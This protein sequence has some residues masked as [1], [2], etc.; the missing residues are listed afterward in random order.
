MRRES[1]AASSGRDSVDN[2]PVSQTS[3]RP[4]LQRSWTREEERLSGWSFGCG[5]A[6]FLGVTLPS[7]ILVMGSLHL[8]WFW[9]RWPLLAGP[10]WAVLAALGVAIVLLSR[11]RASRWRSVALA[12][13]SLGVLVTHVARGFDILGLWGQ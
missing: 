6:L 11:S 5:V 7:V 4:P 9:E 10:E 8:A 12:G 2:R 3:T 1:T 13:V